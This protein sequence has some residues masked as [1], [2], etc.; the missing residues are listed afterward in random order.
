MIIPTFNTALAQ[1]LTGDTLDLTS[2][3]TI[4][5]R[6]TSDAV[7]TRRVEFEHTSAPETFAVSSLDSLSGLHGGGVG[8]SN[9][10]ADF[11]FWVFNTAENQT[12][13][14][15]GEGV[16]IGTYDANFPLHIKGTDSVGPFQNAR[17]AVDNGSRSTTEIRTMFRLI[18][19][20]GSRFTFTDTSLGSVW[21]FNSNSDGDFAI[22][23][24]GTG[25]SEFKVRQSGSIEMG[26]GGSD[27][28]VLDPSGDL[29]IAGALSEGS[30]V[31]QKTEIRTIEYTDV[32]EKVMSMPVKSW[33]YKA[34]DPDV[35]HIGPMAQDFREAFGLGNSDK[36]IAVIDGI[37]VSLA[38][39]KALNQNLELKQSEIEDL[40]SI[41]DTLAERLNKLE[42]LER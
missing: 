13:S 28:F 23:L 30:D 14:V 16:G 32:L 42:K 34:N 36:K 25:G 3:A 1:A 20:G 18:N 29:A 4:G 6:I 7:N 12:L 15:R 8:L 10:D 2:V 5:G 24:N 21:T 26:S 40:R 39:I 41:V 35:R 22:S 19:N 17:I 9:T 33:Q 27:S 37:G 38:S 31:H 11:P